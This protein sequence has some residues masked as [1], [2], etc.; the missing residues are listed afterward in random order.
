MDNRTKANIVLAYQH[1]S[2]CVKALPAREKAEY[3]AAI[4]QRRMPDRIAPMTSLMASS[5]VAICQGVDAGGDIGEL[6]D[7]QLQA[8]EPHGDME[9]ALLSTQLKALIEASSVY[10]EIQG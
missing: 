9:V 10:A 1:A 2:E 4:K 7:L 6:A 3:D 8:C 5:V